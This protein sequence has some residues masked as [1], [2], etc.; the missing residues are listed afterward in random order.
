MKAVVTVMLKPGVLD[1]QGKAIGQALQH[2]GFANVG[3][4]R[5]GKRIELDLTETDP[6]RARAQAAEMARKLLA[7][8]VIERFEI[9]VE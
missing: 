3:A 9:A 1:P 6:A 8:T 7:N 4:V 5:A 2:L